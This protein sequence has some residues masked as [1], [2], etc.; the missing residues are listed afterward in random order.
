MSKE[1]RLGRGLEALLGRV[2]A[3]QP[4]NDLSV[5][6][7]DTDRTGMPERLSVYGASDPDDES[8]DAI[9]G[10][11]MKGRPILDIPIGQIDPNP[12]QP[13][14]DFDPSEIAS[15]ADNLCEHGMIQPITLRKNGERFELIAGERRL[16]AAQTA[17]W[18]TV[19]AYFL[20]V[21]DREMA[22][23]A[24]SENIQRKDLNAIEKA[25]AFRNYLDAYGG[26]Q[27]DLARRL[28]LDRSTI[29]NLMRLLDLPNELQKAI[30]RNE[31]SQGHAR[32][33]L[34]LEEAEQFATARR[35]V[36]ESWSVRQTEE[37]VRN[38]LDA[39]NDAP[40]DERLTPPKRPATTPKDAHLADLEQQFRSLFGSK[41]KLTTNERGGGR[42]VISFRSNDDFERIYQLILNRM[43]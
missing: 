12:Y 26:N 5:S 37:F 1:K 34:P 25:L 43:R 24:L 32:A 8:A 35:I 29:S 39:E 4:E 14:I 23:L 6:A 20:V 22:E 2:A 19:P 17:G 13:R 30:L 42:L 16:R 33:L 18:E 28:G 36:A 11:M 7:A 27:G 38:L 15:L 10:E 41:V 9:L 31:I 40:V 21:D 3:A